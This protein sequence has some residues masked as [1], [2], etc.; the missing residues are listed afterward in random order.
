M[1]SAPQSSAKPRKSSSP[2]SRRK[3]PDELGFEIVSVT[4]SARPIAAAHARWGRGSHPTGLNFGDCFS[5]EVA[6]RLPV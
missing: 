5:Y 2:S 4:A 6:A 3:I 1:P